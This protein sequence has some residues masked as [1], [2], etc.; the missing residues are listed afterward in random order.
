[1]DVIGL[2]LSRK[3]IINNIPLNNISFKKPMKRASCGCFTV[4]NSSKISLTFHPY[5]FN[6]DTLDYLEQY[7]E[8]MKNGMATVGTS[9]IRF[10]RCQGSPMLK[11]QM[12]IGLAS[13]QNKNQSFYP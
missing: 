11:Q 4:R 1:M 8:G 6:K 5:H 12:Q 7:T 9:R 3:G 10:F 2:S 13:K